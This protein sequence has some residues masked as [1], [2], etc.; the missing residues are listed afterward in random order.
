M[1]LCFQNR[2]FAIASV[3]PDEDLCNRSVF[4][5]KILWM[6]TVPEL[7]HEHSGEPRH[8]IRS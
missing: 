8:G 3:L 1:Q 2:T 5:T 4:R 6:A 7:I